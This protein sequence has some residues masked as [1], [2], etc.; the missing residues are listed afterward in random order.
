MKLTAEERKAEEQRLIENGDMENTIDLFGGLYDS[1]HFI[2][3]RIPR[4]CILVAKI[5]Q[6]RDKLFEVILAQYETSCC[7]SY[8]LTYGTSYSLASSVTVT[9]AKL[10]SKVKKVEEKVCFSIMSC[11]PPRIF[12]DFHIVLEIIFSCG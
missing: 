10:D 11:S 7:V 9:T 1:C 3:S 5:V 12:V 6:E 8:A 2:F 4:L